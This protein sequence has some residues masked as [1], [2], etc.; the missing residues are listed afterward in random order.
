MSSD[1]SVPSAVREAYA[2][3]WGL[4]ADEFPETDHMS[5]Q[6]Y[7]REARRLVGDTVFTQNTVMDKTPR[8]NSSIGMGC[9]AY[10]ATCGIIGVRWDSCADGVLH[11]QMGSTRTAKRGMP[12]TPR[13][14]QAAPCTTRHTLRCS[15]AVPVPAAQRCIRVS[16]RCRCAYSL[17]TVGVPGVVV[18]DW[19]LHV[20]SHTGLDPVPQENRG[21]QPAGAGLRL[22]IPC[23]VRD[24]QNGAAVHDP[25]PRRRSR[26]S[27]G[28]QARHGRSGGGSC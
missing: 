11:P 7:I 12:V 4:C 18:V 19:L 16:I 8:G 20:L 14:R 21:V 27:A 17:A 23:G 22:C 28:R 13:P 26:G 9:C 1:P 3:K 6:L 15:A 10:C 2:S 5:P 24:S 25:G